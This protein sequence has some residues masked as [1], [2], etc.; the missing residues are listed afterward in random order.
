MWAVASII[1]LLAG[2][3]QRAP[4]MKKWQPVPRI[5][6][7]WTGGTLREA[8][9]SEDEAAAFQELG[10]PETIRFFRSKPERQRVYAWLYE[11]KEQIVWFV[12]GRRIDYVV[13][14]T[15]TS[16]RPKATRESLQK[17]GIAGGILAGFVGG[18]AALFL[19]LDKDLGLRD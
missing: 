1:L 9:L 5:A 2:C 7:R 19:L 3:S 13:L 10:T 4:Y 12:D 8:K 16:S 17:K 14:D 18:V 15:N 6:H 11:E